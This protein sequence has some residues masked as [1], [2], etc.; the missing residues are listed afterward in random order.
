MLGGF[1]QFI[2]GETIESFLKNMQAVPPN[3]T[4]IQNCFRIALNAMLAMTLGLKKQMLEPT[5]EEKQNKRKLKERAKE[6]DKMA[7]LRA[8]LQLGMMP[9]VFQ[10][11]QQIKAFDVQQ[12]EPALPPDHTGIPKMP[13]W[14]RGHYRRQAV[15]PGWTQ[16][17]LIWIRP[18][19][20]NAGQFKGDLKDTTTTYEAS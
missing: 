13:H 5:Y 6:K 3:G 10:F 15:G 12:T 8:R 11:D 19:L 2:I 7:A 14:R 17:E 1:H 20:I 16:H 4:P 18:V 9:E